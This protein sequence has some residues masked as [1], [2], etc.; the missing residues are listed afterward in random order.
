MKRIDL[1]I[2]SIALIFGSCTDL[3]NVKTI[4]L[5]LTNTLEVA[6]VDEYME[7]DLDKLNL[8]GELKN[9]GIIVQDGE[10]VIPSQLVCSDK[11]GFV[12]NFDPKEEKVVTIKAGNQ[13]MPH[14]YLSRTYAEIAMKVGSEFKDGK[15]L[16]GRFQNFQEVRIPEGHTDHNAL[17]KYEGPGWESD[18]IGYRMYID[19]RNR[20]DIFG[21]KTN[22]L[23][24]K[25]IGVNDLDAEDDSYHYMQEWGKDIFKVGNSLGIGSFGIMHNDEIMMVSERDS[26]FVIISEN[27][28]VESAVDITYYGWKVAN[29]KYDLE[30]EISITAGSRLSRVE[31]EAT[32]N[33]ENFVTGF[34]KHPGTEFSRKINENKWSFISLYGVQTAADY[35]Q[36]DEPMDKLGI[37]VFFDDDNLIDLTESEDSYVLVLKPDD[38]NL[39][40]YFAAAWEQEPDGVKSKEEFYEYLNL[41][42]RKLNNPIYV[43]Y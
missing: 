9:L 6:R 2:L 23:V 8:N 32:N 16:G 30:A 10:R 11:L 22:E 31:L 19:W 43:E 20:I 14:K 38:G 17:F 27:G 21:K 41:I 33:P 15:Y 12:L 34:A 26:V 39:K 29:K 28:P 3:N 36:A 35:G 13:I 18:K 25:N 42:T 7:I 37:A 5:T 40:Y 4:E 24:L 1:T